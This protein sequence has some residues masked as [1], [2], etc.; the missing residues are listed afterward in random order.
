MEELKYDIIKCIRDKYVFSL[1]ALDNYLDN[2]VLNE[3]LINK[4][5]D[6]IEN[7]I[8]NIKIKKIQGLM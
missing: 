4:K 8:N 3:A 1:I 6:R 2:F 5:E 7:L